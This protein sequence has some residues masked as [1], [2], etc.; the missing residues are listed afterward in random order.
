MNRGF[1]VDTRQVDL[2]G[3]V[4]V[5]AVLGTVKREE[6]DKADA[7]ARADTILAMFREF[8]LGLAMPDGIAIPDNVQEYRP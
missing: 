1:R 6:W 5:S 2:L 4:Q 3:T 8:L 7:K